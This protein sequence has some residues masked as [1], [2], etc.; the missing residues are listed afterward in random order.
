MEPTELLWW[1]A[2]FAKMLSCLFNAECPQHLEVQQERFFRARADVKKYHRA[3][4]TQFG[5]SA[6]ISMELCDFLY[7]HMKIV[8][9][10]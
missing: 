8:T 4:G 1:E 10:R 9:E 2:K 6:I 5:T 3:V 7:Q